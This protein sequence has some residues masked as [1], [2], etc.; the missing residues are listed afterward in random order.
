MSLSACV[1]NLAPTTIYRRVPGLSGTSGQG[2]RGSGAR[3]VALPD[4]RWQQRP[5][6]LRTED[7]AL[8]GEGLR[9]AAGAP[10]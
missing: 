4:P 7:Y 8:L 1:R 6:W 3:Q 5:P 9:L 2:T 10:Q